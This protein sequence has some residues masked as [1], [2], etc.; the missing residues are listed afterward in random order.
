MAGASPTKTQQLFDRS[1]RHRSTRHFIICTKGMDMFSFFFVSINI[2]IKYKIPYYFFFTVGK[3]EQCTVGLREHATAL[4]M[5][6]KHLPMSLLSPPGIRAGMLAEAART[7]E[8]IGDRKNLM[9]C[10][11]LLK[12]I[13]TNSSVSD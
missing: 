11:K 13:T 3:G 4:F 6:C 10:Y 5:A 9:Q 7:L 8:K 1:L 12:S 2:Y